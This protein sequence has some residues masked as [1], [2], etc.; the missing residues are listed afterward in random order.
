MKHIVRLSVVA[1]TL[2][3]ATLSASAGVTGGDPRPAA[4]KAQGVTGGDPRPAAVPQ[5][6][7]VWSVILAL[8]GIAS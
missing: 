7:T 1:V 8:V 6:I 5:P 4:V 2:F 3:G